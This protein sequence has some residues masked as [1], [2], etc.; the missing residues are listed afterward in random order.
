M[1]QSNMPDPKQVKQTVSNSQ[2]QRR[3]LDIIGL[4]LEEIITQLEQ[5]N[6]QQKLNRLRASSAH[7]SHKT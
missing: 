6:R 5:H 4:E 1:N 7:H 2:K 3:E